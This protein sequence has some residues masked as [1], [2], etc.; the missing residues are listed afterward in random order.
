MSETLPPRARANR[1]RY[2]KLRASLELRYAHHT[3]V[4]FGYA[5]PVRV[6]LLAG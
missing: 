1:I 5:S 4:S 2:L 3:T 6:E